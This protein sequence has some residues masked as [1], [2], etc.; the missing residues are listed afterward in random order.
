MVSRLSLFEQMLDGL[1]FLHAEGCMHRDIKPEN[2]LATSTPVRAVII[3]F[4]CVTW[5]ASSK[6]H[7]KGT[8]RYL[9]PEIIALKEN[10]APPNTV[11]NNSADIWSMG[12][13]AYELLRASRTRF[14]RITWKYYDEELLSTIGIASALGSGEVNWVFSLIKEMLRWDPK[15]RTKSEQA[16]QKCP[17]FKVERDR[18]WLSSGKR[19]HA[20]DQVE[21]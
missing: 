4:G 17:T 6:D 19:E 13:T 8:I 5:E 7:M 20:E 12:L 3:D 1:A 21:C 16:R 9:A 18:R 14:Q 11:Y 10:T 15:S 2:I